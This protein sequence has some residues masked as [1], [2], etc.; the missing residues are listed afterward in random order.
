MKE[1]SLYRFQPNSGSCSSL[2]LDEKRAGL[3]T[4]GLVAG[5]LS[6]NVLAERAGSAMA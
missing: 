4:N 2:H 3:L 5:F 1:P 6:K